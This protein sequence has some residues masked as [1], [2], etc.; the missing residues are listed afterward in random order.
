MSEAPYTHEVRETKTLQF[1]RW[2]TRN[3]FP[4]AMA[5]IF[6]TLFFLYPIVNAVLTGMGMPLPGPAVRVDTSARAQWPDHPF[7]HAQDSFAKKFGTSSLVAIAVVVKDGNIFTPETL[8]KIHEITRRLDGV[9][10]DSQNDK[11]DELR[12]QLEE[13]GKSEEQIVKELDRA[14][15]PYPVNHDQIRSVAHSST[16]VVQIE[17]DGSITSDVLMKKVPENQDDADHLRGL[18]LQN[19]PFIYGRLVSWD[20]KGAL[21]TGGFI[22]DRLNTS[23]TYTAVFNHV[24]QI[25]KDF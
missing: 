23:Q 17:P 3:R 4:I 15:P 24:E 2:E 7:I 21:I 16:R 22:T 25:K 6:T 19:P 11:R 20:E 14:Y 13:Q 12:T 8:Q 9:G 18:V 10:Y 1:A 5:L